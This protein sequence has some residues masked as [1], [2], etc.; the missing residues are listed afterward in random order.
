MS[1]ASDFDRTLETWLADV[2]PT[3]P[4]AGL[5]GETL[6][7]RGRHAAPPGLADLGSMDMGGHCTAGRG[8]RPLPAGGRGPPAA[9]HRDRGGGD[10][11]RVTAARAAVRLDHRRIHHDGFRRRHRRRT[12]GWDAATRPRAEGRR[13]DQP[14][15]VA[16]RPAP[17]VLASGRSREAVGVDRRRP[18]RRLAP[19]AR[20]RCHASRARR[21]AEPAEQHELVPGG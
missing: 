4:P 6:E 17:R 11:R 3:S 12:H 5:L 15:L 10:P 19:G 1:T 20:K 21:G 14:D 8:G 9:R 7:P 16:R 2:R 13:V 18:V